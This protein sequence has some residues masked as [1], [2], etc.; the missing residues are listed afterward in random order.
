MANVIF[1]N[2][3]PEIRGMTHND[4]FEFRITE[5]PKGSVSGVET[6]VLPDASVAV[7]TI[8]GATNE[9]IIGTSPISLGGPKITL[10]S[11]TPFQCVVDA[12]GL[13]TKGSGG[14]GLCTIEATSQYGSRKYSRIIETTGSAI[15]STIQN[16]VPGSLAH[17]VNA[18]ISSYFAG[19]TAELMQLHLHESN[20]RQWRA[21]RIA[22]TLD[23][24]WQSVDA[25][26]GPSFPCSLISPRHA[27]CAAHAGFSVG[28][29][30]VFLSPSGEIKQ[31]TVTKTWNKPGS[32]LGMVYFDTPVTGCAI[33]KFAPNFQDKTSLDRTIDGDASSYLGY[34]FPVLMTPINFYL[35]PNE[36][37]GGRK[38][39]PAGLNGIGLN[40]L[41]GWSQCNIVSLDLFFPG[42]RHD[43]PD[44]SLSVVRGGDSGSS[45][46]FPLIEPGQSSP[47]SVL[48]SAMHSA[49][50]G[51]PYSLM[52]PAINDAM[53]AIKDSGDTTVYSAQIADLSAFP[54]YP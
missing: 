8:T 2:S 14:D 35:M 26:D 43:S 49:S 24:S 25:N 9:F 45:I 18:L 16:Y 34:K 5:V 31:A 1:S 54:N 13:V 21:N 4:D 28:R 46:F 3:G 11:T 6:V 50:G 15:E 38:L 10:Q 27:L 52:V 47:S 23:M 30:Y 20:R 37:Y 22:S 33:A 41:T 39:M 51:P 32:D 19:R 36:V 42:Y 12:D 29:Q 53:N 40:G 48:I 17:H 44:P 7:S